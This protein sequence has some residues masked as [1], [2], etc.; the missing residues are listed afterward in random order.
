MITTRKEDDKKNG[1]KNHPF[2]KLIFCLFIYRL[3]INWNLYEIKEKFFHLYYN[4]H[5]KLDHNLKN[6]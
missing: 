2:Q 4:K 1:E 6:L 5:K 3:R